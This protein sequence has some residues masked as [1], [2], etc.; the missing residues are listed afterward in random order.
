M[1]DKQFKVLM[2]LFAV[3]APCSPTHAGRPGNFLGASSAIQA[4]KLKA[5]EL[6]ELLIPR[7]RPATRS[8]VCPT[9][10]TDIPFTVP[11]QNPN[12]PAVA[13]YV[14]PATGQPTPTFNSPNP[15]P[16][17][18]AATYSVSWSE[19]G[20]GNYY[21]FNPS[22]VAGLEQVILASAPNLVS[23]DRNLNLDNQLNIDLTS[24][25]NQAG[26]FSFY[27]NTPAEMEMRYDK[28]SNR[29]YF[30]MDAFSGLDITGVSLEN[31]GG[32]TFGVSDSGVIN[33]DTTWTI[34]TI[35]NASLIPDSNGCPGDIT[36]GGVDYDYCRAG[37]DQ[38]AY[39]FA[40]NI[41]NAANYYVSTSA[42]VIQKESLL[43]GGPVIVTAFRDIVGFPGEEQPYRDA[44]ST[45]IPVMNF[46]DNPEFG[47]FIGQ[48]PLLWGKLIIYRVINPGSSN[49]TLSVASTIDV[50]TTY[51]IA[52]PTTLA[53]FAGNQYSFLG[54]IGALDDRLKMAHIRNHQLYTAQN[55]L[56]DST[57]TGTSD[58]DRYGIRWYQLDL[59]GDPTGQGTGTET[60][61]TVP[62]LIQAGTLFDPS[63]TD[64]IWYYQPAIMTNKNGDMSLSGV[65]SG[66]NY[67][68]SAFN[69]GRRASDPLAVLSIGASPTAGVFQ[70]GS[71]PYT[72]LLATV[73]ETGPFATAFGQRISDRQYT[74]FDPVDD[75]TM[76]AIQ[77]YIED[78]QLKAII[79][80]LV[81]AV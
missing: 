26:D 24:F 63:E 28:F 7:K 50:P 8:T 47:Y 15:S 54:N 17:A 76:W 36:P 32:V 33:E 44:A 21:V 39:Y 35:C 69:V 78:G 30:A 13:F 14:N 55:I 40:F 6:G 68:I 9:L 27:D 57:G 3:A 65:L 53:P 1:T 25:A 37:V 58:G 48:D 19:P 81:P 34:V 20:V 79:A 49:P 12:A 46:D 18:I 41:F 64:P 23:F 62:A 4:R 43:A 80:S 16:Q 67:S 38:N 70:R 61:A 77:E 73:S 11:Q 45:L 22:M 71:G 5:S 59:T 31:N 10:P 2:T 42:F 72:Q 29:F 56:V 60:A 66:N 51:Y 75:V 52:S 74:C